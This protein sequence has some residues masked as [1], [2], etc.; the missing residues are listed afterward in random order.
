MQAPQRPHNLP[1]APQLPLQQVPQLPLQQETLRSGVAQIGRM[2]VGNAER[3]ARLEQT[4]SAQMVRPV[5]LA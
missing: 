1:Q 3:N 2:Q 4:L 5:L